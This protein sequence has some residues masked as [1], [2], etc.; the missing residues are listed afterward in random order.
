M[1]RKMGVVDMRLAWAG[2]AAGEFFLVGMGKKVVRL[3]CRERRNETEEQ[4]PVADDF[5]K[6]VLHLF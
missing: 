4:K 5:G 6:I 1:R 3:S 2:I